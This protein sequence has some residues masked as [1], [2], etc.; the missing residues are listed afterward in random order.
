MKN[1]K[2]WFSLGFA[3]LCA[4]C[5]FSLAGSAQ[6]QTV[7][8]YDLTGIGSGG[9][10]WEPYGTVTQATDGNFYG[11]ATN[12]IFGGGGNIFRMTPD[13]E[14]TNF[15]TFVCSRTTCPN[16]GFPITPPILGVDGN[17]YGITAGTF[18][19]L[20]LSGEL[21]TLYTFSDPNGAENPNGIVLGSDGNFYGTSVYGGGSDGPGTIFKITPEGQYTQLHSF[22]S[23]A[24]CAD[25]EKPFFAP[26]EGNDGN[27]YG[28]TTVGGSTGGGVIN[29]C[30][31]DDNHCT[32]GS[33]PYGLAKDAD[34]NFEG[35]TYS[36]VFKITPSGQYSLLNT[37]SNAQHFGSPYSQLILGSDGALYGMMDGGGS[38]S[39]VGRVRGAIYRVTTAGDSK[40]LYAFCQCGS[41]KGFNPISGLFQGTDGNFYGTT[42]FGGIGPDT[43]EDWG[44]GTVFKY[45]SG[46]G[47]I[48][49]TVPAM[50]KA[51]QTVLIL[52][53]HLSGTTGVMFNGMQA[54]FTV[55]SD[56]YIKVMVPAGATSGKVSVVTS[57]STLN[58]NSQFVVTK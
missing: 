26:V 23:Q 33:V 24:N 30:G 21:R 6:A 14:V 55:E 17:L 42:A 31:P 47:P 12:G 54:N 1:S 7:S 41:G 46:L 25:G 40:T 11:T 50:G 18:Y 15:Y 3:L 51:G 13:G 38:G 39:W 20:T 19:R 53:N 27:F 49:E 22:C 44:Y 57:S 43:N 58:S 9:T 2:F 10:G 16:G 8:F 48:V 56:T 36:G 29:F 34:G 45:A 28:A 32:T 52:G 5:T 37:L 4:A 35:T